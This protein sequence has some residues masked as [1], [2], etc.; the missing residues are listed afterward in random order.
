[1]TAEEAKQRAGTKVNAVSVRLE[2]EGLRQLGEVSRQ[3]DN[4]RDWYRN[5]AADLWTISV[6]LTTMARANLT[7]QTS[8][9]CNCAA[10][11]CVVAAKLLLG[12]R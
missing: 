3:F 6:L 2:L 5:C 7:M 4:E 11:C 8:R 12:K 1:M 10:L 9:K